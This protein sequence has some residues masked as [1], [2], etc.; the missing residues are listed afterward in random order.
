MSGI[1]VPAPRRSLIVTVHDVAPPF[2]AGVRRLLNELDRRA[3]RPRVLKVVPCYAGR[4]PLAD[5]TDLCR[6]LRAEVA[7]GSEIVVAW[8]DPPGTG[9]LARFAR[10]TLARLLAGWRGGR[11]P[12]PAGRG[13]PRC[14]PVRPTH[15]RRYAGGRAA[16]VLCPG[17]A[18]QQGGD[19]QPSQPPGTAFC[20]SRQ[21]CATCGPARSSL[22]PGRAIW[23][24]AASTNGWC[25]WV[26]GPWR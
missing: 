7:A 9:R 11:I 21:R 24:L 16:G 23:A 1:A 14:G 13:R 2:A 10:G 12:E 26:M 8:L 4:W 6:L 5:D 22:L 18:A 17:L 3:I 25:R 19:G 20:W 15:A